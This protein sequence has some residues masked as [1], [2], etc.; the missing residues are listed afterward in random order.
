MPIHNIQGYIIVSPDHNYKGKYWTRI[1]SSI[2]QHYGSDEISDPAL[3]QKILL[4]GFQRFCKIFTEIIDSEDRASFYLHVHN[5]HENS[6]ELWKMQIRDEPIN[7]N[8]SLLASIR[9]VL[10]LILE[11]CCKSY[12]ISTANFETEIE[13][14]SEEY[15]QLLEELLYVGEKAI[16]FS[17]YAATNQLFPK[18]HGIHI[19]NGELNIYSYEPFH[20]L[21][22]FLLTDFDRHN[23]QV[24][25]Y[26]TLAELK[27]ILISD[28]GVNYDILASIISDHVNTPENRFGML[29]PIQLIES[30]VE[31]YGYNRETIMDFY[32]GLTLSNDN[33]LSIEE[34]IIKNQ[35]I[36]R[37]IYRPIL[38]LRID[39][40]DYWLVGMNKW[41]ESFAT[42]STNALPFSICA[43]EWFKY[44]SIKEFVIK[45]GNNHDKILE[46]P[47]EELLQKYD[48]KYDRNIK[49]IR[50]SKSSHVRIDTKKGVGEIDFIY[51]D[52]AHE[53]L[54]IAECKHNRSRFDMYNWRR[55]T[56]NFKATYENQLSK[57]VSWCRT[58]LRLL[59]THYSLKHPN[60]SLD[61]TK[62]MVR[63]I[64]IINAP[65][66]YMYNGKFRAFTIHDFENL[67]KGEYIDRVFRFE[68]E[69]DQT[70]IEIHHPYFDNL[71]RKMK[72][73]KIA[74]DISALTLGESIALVKKLKTDFRLS[75]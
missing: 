53:I 34:C 68:N 64:F 10:K 40:E 33:A 65:T 73:K 75:Q 46:D 63:G 18:S 61:I 24:V 52:E 59:N 62:Y 11:Q 57:K 48:R 37:I 74:K 47:I 56:T 19:V 51:V 21:K 60:E 44:K 16:E 72:L 6:C 17:E 55:D 9:R 2:Q 70:E 13:Q 69:D 50:K 12:L 42:L 26:N 5:F 3:V 38:R 36:N 43:P 4:E 14:N 30:L 22:N 54:Y 49:A 31:Q 1:S 29:M 66:F 25:L 35:D 45:V 23:D 20:F 32:A 41:L 15:N 39:G 71:I 27:P 8:S 67:L 58:N 28:L 7:I